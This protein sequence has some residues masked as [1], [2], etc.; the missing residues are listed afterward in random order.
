MLN[1]ELAS[2]EFL[3]SLVFFYNHKCTFTPKN[4][5]RI[6]ATTG[7]KSTTEND[8]HSGHEICNTTTPRMTRKQR[9]TSETRTDEHAQHVRRQ[10]CE[11]DRVAGSVSFKH[12]HIGRQKKLAPKRVI[13]GFIMCTFYFTLHA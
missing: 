7:K 10:F 8:V 3:C 6:I 9:I 13:Y 11:E 4:I 12:L 2:C 5:S 1:T